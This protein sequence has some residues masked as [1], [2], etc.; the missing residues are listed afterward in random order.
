MPCNHT[1]QLDKGSERSHD[2]DGLRLPHEPC[3]A[4]NRRR[5]RYVHTWLAKDRLV[6]EIK[7]RG[8]SSLNPVVRGSIS[9]PQLKNNYKGRVDLAASADRVIVQGTLIEP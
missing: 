5:R 2:K 3:K 6:V 9:S 1:T 8:D 4:I 7:E